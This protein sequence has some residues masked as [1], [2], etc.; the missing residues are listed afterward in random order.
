MSFRCV[1]VGAESIGSLGMTAARDAAC[2]PF[3]LLLVAMKGH[4]DGE[5]SGAASLVGGVE[6]LIWDLAVF[7]VKIEWSDRASS[8]LSGHSSRRFDRLV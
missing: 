4:A 3:A 5:A 7:G 1:T 6:V 2:K 8:F